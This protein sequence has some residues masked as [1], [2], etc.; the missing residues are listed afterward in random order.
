MDTEIRENADSAARSRN[1]ENV[2]KGFFMRFEKLGWFKAPKSAQ[3]F[4]RPRRQLKYTRV[5]IKIK[6][7]VIFPKIFR[8]YVNAGKEVPDV[9]V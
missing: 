4:L 5:L 3:Y 6:I 1:D 8:L 9:S 2:N 7:H